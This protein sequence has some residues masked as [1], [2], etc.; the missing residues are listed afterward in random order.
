METINET[1]KI[2][3]KDYLDTANLLDR[4][5]NE[6]RQYYEQLKTKKKE[7]PSITFEDMQEELESLTRRHQR[8][9]LMM[10]DL[11]S[12]M[13]RLTVLNNLAVIGDVDLGLS[14]DDKAILD[15]VSKVTNLFFSSNKGEVVDLQKDIIEKF[16]SETATKYITE[17]N[18]REQ[19]N[20]L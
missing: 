8:G 6:D 12:L 4:K 5:L 3:V 9:V 15:N 2:Q 11:E 1:L 20:N 18:L 17:D 10:K 19:F 7:D 16:I 13:N 14:D